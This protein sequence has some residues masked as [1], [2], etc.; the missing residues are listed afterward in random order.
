M[1]QPSPVFELRVVIT[2]D[3]YEAAL[4]FWRDGLGLP[5]IRDFDGGSL[6]AAGQATIEILERRAAEDVDRIELGRVGASGV[7]LAL[8][9]AEADATGEDLEAAG[10]TRL[11]GPVD[12]PWGHRNVRLRTP[13]GIEL[14]LFAVNAGS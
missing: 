13:D 11:G 12:T 5:L 3:D 8:E 6:L 1:S 14:T 9:V 7:R 10:A 4:R 2:A